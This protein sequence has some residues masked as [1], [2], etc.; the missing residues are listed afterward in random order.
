MRPIFGL[1]RDPDALATWG[2][3]SWHGGFE[4]DDGQWWC[5]VHG[6]D[7]AACRRFDD[8]ARSAADAMADALLAP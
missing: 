2:E 4:D 7:L 5:D 1:D 8:E 3:P 6:D